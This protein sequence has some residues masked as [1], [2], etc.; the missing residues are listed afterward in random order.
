MLEDDVTFFALGQGEE[1]VIR[2]D[3]ARASDIEGPP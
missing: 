2:E 3:V 1:G